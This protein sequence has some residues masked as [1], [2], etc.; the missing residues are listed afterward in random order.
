MYPYGN[1]RVSL[2]RDYAQAQASTVKRLFAATD[3]SMA[4]LTDESHRAEAI[5]LL[6]TAAHVR[7][8]DAEAS[9]DLLRRIDYF[10]PTSRISRKE[11]QNLIA[12]ERTLTSVDP[13]FTPDR[14]AMPG[15]T[16][17]VD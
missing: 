8:E 7:K 6:V 11:L 15:I 2:R 1:T 4:W 12:V 9:Y 5:E 13:A 10:A 3:K 14:L 16:E 17:L